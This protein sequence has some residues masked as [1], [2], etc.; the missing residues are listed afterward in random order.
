MPYVDFPGVRFVAQLRRQVESKK[1]GRKR[2]PET[3]Y[4]LTSLPPEQATAEP[5]LL[6]D[7]E[8]HPLGARRGLARGPQSHPQGYAAASAGGLR[9]LRD[10]ARLLKTPNIKRRMAQLRLNPNQAVALLL[11]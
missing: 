3:V 10:L 1:D 8:S 6:G 2:K 4:L 9:Q 5:V 7:R 11:G